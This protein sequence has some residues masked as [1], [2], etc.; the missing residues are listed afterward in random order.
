MENAAQDEASRLK[1]QTQ[2][3]S[4]QA[5]IA[6]TQQAQSNIAAN[7]EKRE[8]ENQNIRAQTSATIDA[9]KKQIENV[10]KHIQGRS[11]KLRKAKKRTSGFQNMGYISVDPYVENTRNYSSLSTQYQTNHSWMITQ[12]T[13]QY[14]YIRSRGNN[15]SL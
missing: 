9:G 12:P 8:G 13:V 2:Q 5:L 7:Q 1:A 10:R 6:A 14:D 3:D 11:E 4:Q 15:N